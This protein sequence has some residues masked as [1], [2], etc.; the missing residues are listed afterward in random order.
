MLGKMIYQEIFKAGLK[1]IGKD[2]LIKNRA[3]LEFLEN[4]GSYHSDSVGYGANTTEST[5]VTW[6]LLEWKLQILKRPKYGQMLDVHTWG[7][8]MY[9]FFTYRD[10]EIYDEQNNLC[11]IA[12][13]KWALIDIHTR[14]MV[15]I[16]EDIVEK[17]KPEE[18]KCVFPESD[19]PRLKAPNQFSSSILYKTRRKDIDLNG[20]MHN[21]YYLDLAY[22]ALPEEVYEK[23]PF[24]N[25]RISYKNEI[26][27]GETVKCEYVKEED[28]HI[29]VVSSEDGNSLHAI[30]QLC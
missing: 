13:S 21:L 8:G 27:L 17:Y 12:T 19:I 2:N 25:V 14:K 23:R 30:I 7:R 10:F 15:R 22:E 6:I 20:H 3:I 28:K 11:V 1:D 29:V 4:I 5:G 26:R 9:K 16:T 18:S 24:D